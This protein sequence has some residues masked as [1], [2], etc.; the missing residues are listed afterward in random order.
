MTHHYTPI[1]MGKIRN[2]DNTKCW[3][4]CGA[5]WTLITGGNAKWCSHSRRQF[6]RS[7]RTKHTLTI[8]SSNHVPWYLPKWI[9]NLCPHK[10]LYTN[11]YSSF[12]HNG[13]DLEATKTSFGRWMDKLWYIQTMDYYSVLKRNEL[14]SHEKTWRNLKCLL[15]NERSQSEKSIYYMIPATWHSRERQN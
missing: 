10:N 14:S 15:L 1:R 5:T 8:W 4:E 2:T 7:Y 6:G 13:Q 12:I 3:Q 11:V 9:E